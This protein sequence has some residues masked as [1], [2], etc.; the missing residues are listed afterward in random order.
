MYDTPHAAVPAS[1][2]SVELTATPKH[3]RFG[4]VSRVPIRMSVRRDQEKRLIGLLG[5]H[6]LDDQP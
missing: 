4:G 1:I 3:D 5:A 6:H 2:Y